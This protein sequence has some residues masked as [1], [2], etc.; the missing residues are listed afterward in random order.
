M[1]FYFRPLSICIDQCTPGVLVKARV[2]LGKAETRTVAE[3][4][5]NDNHIVRLFPDYL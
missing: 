5:L 3:I 4:C 2:Q 1:F